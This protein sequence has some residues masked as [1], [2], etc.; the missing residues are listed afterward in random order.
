MWIPAALIPVRV[1]RDAWARHLAARL[2]F[3]MAAAAVLVCAPGLVSAVARWAHADC[4]WL[5]IV[6]WPCPGCGVTTSLVAL[7]SG[8]L[9][10]A[11]RGNP[12]GLAVGAA[13]LAQAMVAARGLWR[14]PG[15][16]CGRV[17]LDRQDRLVLAALAAAW[18]VRLSGAR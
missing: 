6:G 10:G 7:A 2:L 1:G 13:L 8:D 17:W 16:A 15:G 14:G 18:M 9:A 5:A 3:S 11:A 4:L 12:A